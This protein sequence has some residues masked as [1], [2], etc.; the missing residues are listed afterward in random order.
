MEVVML[1]V[2]GADIA[3]RPR[4]NA[5]ALPLISPP[6][7]CGLPIAGV[8]REGETKLD[9]SLLSVISYDYRAGACSG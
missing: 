3:S 6:D 2:A 7:T 8:F 1:L 5:A 4:V 9:R